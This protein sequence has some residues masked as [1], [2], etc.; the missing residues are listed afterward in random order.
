MRFH[1]YVLSGLTALA[2]LGMASDAL[3]GGRNPGSMLL[4]PE[5][6]NREGDV[7]LL[8]VTN[9]ANSGDD[10]TVEFVYIG[11]YADCGDSSGPN[12]GSCDVNCE[13]FNRNAVLT[14]NDTLTLITNY[15]NPQHEQGYVYVFAK[16]EAGAPMAHNFLIGNLMTIDGIERFEYSMNPVAYEGF[17]GDLNG[18]GLRDMDGDEYEQNAQE[19][20]IPRFMGQG[21]MY[22]SELIFIGLTGGAAFSTTVDFLIYNDNEEVFSSEY[23]FRCWDRVRLNHISGIF[24]NNFLK[25]FT[26]HASNEILGASGRESGWMR[27]EGHHA[28]STSTTLSNPAIYAVLLERVGDRGAAD[29]PFENG[30]NGNGALLARSLDGTL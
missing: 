7:T 11:R 3:A 23:T 15:H 14:P 16:D 20:L 6:D 13:E 5:F 19:I 26:D 2:G 22:R 17:A 28:S 24:N 9:T 4:Y 1:K 10:V 29:L 30:Q 8:T 25:D 12:G 27:M 21:G 18:N